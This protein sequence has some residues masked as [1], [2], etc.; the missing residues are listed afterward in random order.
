MDFRI[1][2][3]N[4]PKERRRLQNRAAQRK[5]RRKHNQ[6]SGRD[7]GI[8]IEPSNINPTGSHE[9]L[10]VRPASPQ[11]GLQ[12]SATVPE[13]DQTDLDFT[14]L[15]RVTQFGEGAS[16]PV[17][18]PAQYLNDGLLWETESNLFGSAL[19]GPY[20]LHAGGSNPEQ[21]RHMQL[22]SPPS[23]SD[24][25]YE[26]PS[27]GSLQQTNNGASLGWSTL[28]PSRASTCTERAEGQGHNSAH[29]MRPVSSSVTPTP[30]LPPDRALPPP[31]VPCD[32]VLVSD[33]WLGT[34]HIAAQKGHDCILRMLLQNNLD[35]DEEDSDSWTPLAH[36]VAGGHEP[37][38]GLLLAHGA[39]VVEVDWKHRSSVLHLA[40]KY[41]QES[42]LA[43]LLEHQSRAESGAKAVIDAYDDTGRTALH[44]AIET[45]FEA[46]V[47]ML[48]RHGASPRLKAR[49]A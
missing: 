46:G 13:Q 48:L 28:G 5:F 35:C 38:V 47:V 40:V 32:P 21:L 19:P 1:R 17:D 26:L 27:P 11:S 31:V 15:F 34:L 42:I 41:Q 37:V 10:P 8:A 22:S 44:M 30:L 29:P 33:R 14:G 2:L 9:P 3:P 25:V 4:N 45:G 18:E 24:S 7:V 12:L 49:K 16:E 43:K 20:V 6:S 36:A 39:R 23:G